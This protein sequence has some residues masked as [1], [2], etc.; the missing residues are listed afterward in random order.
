M[1]VP[2]IANVRIRFGPGARPPAAMPSVEREAALAN[3]PSRGATRLLPVPGGRMSGVCAPEARTA[4]RG[5]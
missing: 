3:E 2:I 4:G 5:R 1:R